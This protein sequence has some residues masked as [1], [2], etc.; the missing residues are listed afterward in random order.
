MNPLY[1]LTAHIT[2]F[3]LKIY[4]LFNEK[5]KLFIKG[6]NETSE[7]LSVLTK[8]DNVIWFHAASL[9]EFEQARPIIEEVK[10]SYPINKIVVTFFS[11]S[12]Y[13]IYKDYE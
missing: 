4:G 7:K 1:N 8:E 12:G 3:I 11:T 2:F 10:K 6:R 13:D 5:I 9:G